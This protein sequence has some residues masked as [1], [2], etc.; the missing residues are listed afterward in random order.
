MRG[1]IASRDRL[2]RNHALPEPSSHLEALHR[3][4]I[5]NTVWRGNFRLGWGPSPQIN[6]GHVRKVLI[7]LGKEPLFAGNVLQA[8]TQKLL[9][10]QNA[11]FAHEGDINLTVLL[12][13][14]SSVL[15]G[16]TS[17]C[18]DKVHVR[19]A[20]VGRSLAKAP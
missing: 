19:N 20:A 3:N 9:Q 2:P 11:P 1:T 18:Q 17:P 14:V 8:L 12:L 16:S 10:V 6:V 7:S 15:L 4:R 13:F 5:A